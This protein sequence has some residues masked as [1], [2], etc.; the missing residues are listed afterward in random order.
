MDGHLVRFAEAEPRFDLAASAEGGVLHQRVR[1]DAGRLIPMSICSVVVAL[2]DVIA[3]QC[4]PLSKWES[5]LGHELRLMP[6]RLEEGDLG[7]WDARFL[8]VWFHGPEEEK[9]GEASA[10]HLFSVVFDFGRFNLYGAFDPIETQREYERVL[11]CLNEAL[12]TALISDEDVSV[13]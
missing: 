9:A 2:T 7:W 1:A 10:A 6:Q 3:S 4:A 5:E 8:H 11:T 13:W 12:G